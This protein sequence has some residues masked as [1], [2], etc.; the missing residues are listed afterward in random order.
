MRILLSPANRSSTSVGMAKPNTGG[1]SV[2][3]TLDA[4]LERFVSARQLSKLKRFDVWTTLC[5]NCTTQPSD[6][7]KSA[8]ATAGNEAIK[9]RPYYEASS[10]YRAGEPRLNFDSTHQSGAAVSGVGATLL[11]SS[12]LYSGS[13]RRITA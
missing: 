6:S 8:S 7:P 9:R 2:V 3:K 1:Y 5:W 12:Q 11:V 4:T 10:S 13:I